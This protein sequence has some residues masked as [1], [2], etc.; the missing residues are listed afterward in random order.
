MVHL[1]ALY[2][3]DVWG[4]I[5][6]SHSVGNLSGIIERQREKKESIDE[7]VGADI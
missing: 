3:I 6:A 4:S 2:Y 5:V 7:E 1:L